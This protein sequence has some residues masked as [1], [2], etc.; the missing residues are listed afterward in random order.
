MCVYMCVCVYACIRR[1]VCDTHH[2]LTHTHHTLT[3]TH[4]TLTLTH[5]VNS[6]I[7]SGKDRN[8]VPKV[9]TLLDRM[10]SE[11]FVIPKIEENMKVMILVYDV[12]CMMYDV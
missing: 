10:V 2:T 3:H 11:E 12:R 6:G 4:H 8:F 5:T 7:L 1:C 9:S